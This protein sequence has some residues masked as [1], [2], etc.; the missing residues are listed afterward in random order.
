MLEFYHPKEMTQDTHIKQLINNRRL[1]NIESNEQCK[2]WVPWQF[3]EGTG[4][5][6]SKT[7]NGAG[8]KSC[9][10]GRCLIDD[11]SMVFFL[12]SI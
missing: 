10:L 7:V 12:Q 5:K 6:Q 3:R 8:K 11:T 4:S 2:Q 9:F 1:T